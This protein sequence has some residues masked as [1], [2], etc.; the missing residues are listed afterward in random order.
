MPRFLNTYWVEFFTL[1]MKAL[2]AAC[3]PLILLDFHRSFNDTRT[4]SSDEILTVKETA[5]LLKTTRQQVRKMI[6]TKN[7]RLLVRRL[8]H[9][10]IGVV[11]API[12]AFYRRSLGGFST[13]SAQPCPLFSDSGSKLG[14]RL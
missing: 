4:M 8:S 10:Q 11:S 12:C 2:L 6:A 7:S 1:R 5:V 3:K 9:A 13:V 14:Q